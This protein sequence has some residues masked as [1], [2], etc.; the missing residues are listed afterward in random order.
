[1]FFR[2]SPDRVVCR[3]NVCVDE[4]SADTPSGGIDLTLI[5]IIAIVAL[6]GIG[7][8]YYFTKVK[9]GGGSKDE[10]DEFGNEGDEEKEA[11]D[12]EEFY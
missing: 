10:G 5:L 11:F 8:W 12:D 9:K 4:S 3:N 7:A 6:G 2:F 1:M